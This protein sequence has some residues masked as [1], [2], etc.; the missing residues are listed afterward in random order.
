MTDPTLYLARD[1]DDLVMVVNHKP[2]RCSVAHYW[3]N[4]GW[5]GSIVMTRAALDSILPPMS[6]ARLM[7]A[8]VEPMPPAC[9]TTPA[10][11]A[12]GDGMKQV[13]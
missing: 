9:D 8:D 5:I 6:R 12:D 2:E 11:S 3:K 1:G 4:D 7:V 13:S 10:L